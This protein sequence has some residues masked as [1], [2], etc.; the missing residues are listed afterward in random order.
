MTPTPRLRFVE[1]LV[2]APEYGEGIKR[3]VR[4]L[5]Q[6]WAVELDGQVTPVGDWRD[7]L[8]E[9]SDG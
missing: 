2:P 1:R 4:V 3:T 7:V 8:T 6:W 5:Q 9:K